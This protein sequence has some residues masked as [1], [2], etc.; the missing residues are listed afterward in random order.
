MSWDMLLAVLV[1]G[2]GGSLLRFWLARKWPAAPGKIPRGILAANLTGSALAGV[3]TASTML[4]LMPRSWTLV[5]VAGLC[6]GLTTFSTWAVDS[7]LALEAGSRGVAVRNILYTVIGSVL[8][9]SATMLIT[10]WVAIAL[11]AEL[12]R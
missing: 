9:F 3:F 1:A 5:L 2:A 6:G 12:L 10:L 4:V 11:F 7:V 8:L